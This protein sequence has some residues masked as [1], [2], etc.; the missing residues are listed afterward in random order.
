MGRVNTSYAYGIFNA[1]QAL[2]EHLCWPV[3]YTHALCC[4]LYTI[5]GLALNVLNESYYRITTH[6]MHKFYTS[7]T[8]AFTHQMSNQ[9]VVQLSIYNRLCRTPV[10]YSNHY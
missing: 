1:L 7:H 5:L 4:H 6:Y 8:H 2:Q 3:H 9:A 10:P